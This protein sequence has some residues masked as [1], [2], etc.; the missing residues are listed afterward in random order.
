MRLFIDRLEA[1]GSH[2]PDRAEAEAMADLCRMVDGLP[3]GIELLVARVAAVGP[4]EVRAELEDRPE[5]PAGGLVAGDDRHASLDR[6]LSSTVELLEPAPRALFSRLSVFKGSFDRAAVRAVGGQRFDPDDLAALVD[7]ALV[8][9]VGVEHAL[10]RYRLL[11]TTRVYA[12]AHADEVDLEDAAAQHADYYR[13]LCRRAGLAMEGPDEQEW[14][15]RLHL[16]DANIEAALRW[17]YDHE[18]SGVLAF[19]RGMGRAWYVWADFEET[20]DRLNEMLDAVGRE[21]GADAPLDV[22]WLHHRLGMPRF[23][24]GD[25]AG[26]MAEMERAVQLF[27]ELDD[28]IGLARSLAERG[29]MTVFAEGDTDAALGWYRP[30]IAESRRTGS[31][32]TTAWMLAETAQALVLADRADDEV[33]GM[34]DEAQPALETAGDL[35][36]LAHVCMVRTLAAYARDD[37]RGAEQWAEAGMR[38]SRAAG[39]AVYEQVLLAALGVGRLHRGEHGRAGGLL[40]ESARIAYDTH[41]FFQLGISFQGL[42]ALAAV[43]GRAEDSARLWGAA[44]SLAPAWPLFQ[45]RYFD[46]LMVPARASLGAR[47]DEEVAAGALL[48]V[49][50][51]LELGLGL[52]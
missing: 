4:V 44:T 37:L 33:D 2:D 5:L 52:G 30:A 11:E 17:W 49:E 12:A 39:H 23:L 36:G 47:W 31:A 46:E 27:R 35:I 26:G 51:A 28:P 7:A 13:E 50:E 6:V 10:R 41:N 20:R 19:A 8:S 40:R 42:A 18:P 45:R 9:A 16:D 1:R 43:V 29:Q 22:A 34:L 15:D 48:T 3:L 32:Q 21:Q 24:T 38:R 14:V 25:F